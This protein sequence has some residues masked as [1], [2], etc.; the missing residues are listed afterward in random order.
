MPLLYRYFFNKRFKY[1]YLI[2]VVLFLVLVLWH[3]LSSSHLPDLYMPKEDEMPAD[4]YFVTDVNSINL[5][6]ELMIYK[7]KNV[8]INK[9]SLEELAEKL[10]LEDYIIQ[11]ITGDQWMVYA[12]GKMLLVDCDT[13]MWTYQ[14]ISARHSSALDNTNLP[15][16]D[17]VVKAARKYLNSIGINTEEFT[18]VGVGSSTENNKIVRK[19]AYFYRQLQGYE[20]LGASRLVVDIGPGNKIEGIAKYFRET[21]AY[22]VYKLKSPSEAV[23]ELMHGRAQFQVPNL[24]TGEAAVYEMH[25]A[26]YGAPGIVSEQ[27]F[28]Q[29]V[30]VFNG[31]IT[32][33]EGSVPFNALVPA[34]RGVNI[35]WV[36]H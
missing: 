24:I 6:G 8:D 28:L 14:D 36:K 11:K 23:S 35:Q 26:Y 30:F 18:S 1:S 12:A 3:F 9:E 7:Y 10:E 29:P 32:T 27:H 20:V 2:L 13:G 16:D 31:E 19:S 33:N 22:K 15:S 34:V 25:L 17:E 4:I 21:E 5:P